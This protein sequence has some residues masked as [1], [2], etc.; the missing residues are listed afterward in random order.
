MSL[1]REANMAAPDYSLQRVPKGCRVRRHHEK[2]RRKFPEENPN[3]EAI[4]DKMCCL[5]QGQIQVV[6]RTALDECHDE[7]HTMNERPVKSDTNVAMFGFSL[8]PDVLRHFSGVW[9]SL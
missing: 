3:A 7:C 5:L 4:T 1:V 9:C 2:H 8:F 6:A